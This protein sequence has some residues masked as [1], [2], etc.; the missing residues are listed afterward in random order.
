MSRNLFFAK[1]GYRISKELGNNREA[2]CITY[3][4]E[5]ND[6]EA[7]VVIKE[8]R[9]SG[10]NSQWWSSQ[11]C[12]EENWAKIT[13]DREI[14]ILQ[15]LSHPCIPRYLTSFKTPESYCV[16]QEYKKAPSLAEKYSFTLA[17]IKQIA[18]SVLE[19][20]VY[21]QQRIPAI[22]HRD[23]KPENI[24][25]D[26]QLNAYLID[27]GLARLS[28]KDLSVNS[29]VAGTL[30]F[31]AP[32]EYFGHSPTE[33][34]D[35]Y[36][37]GATLICL[38]SGTSSGDIGKLVNEEYRFDLKRLEPRLSSEFID[39]LSKMVEPNLKNRF[40]HAAIALEELKSISVIDSEVSTFKNLHKKLYK[41]LHQTI[42]TRKTMIFPGIASISALIVFGVTGANIFN[43]KLFSRSLRP[44]TPLGSSQIHWSMELNETATGKKSQRQ[45]PE[46]TK[47]LKTKNCWSCNLNNISLILANLENATLENSS[48]R[49][50]DLEEV[51]FQNANLKNTYFEGSNLER[52][53]LLS[54]NLNGSSL[55]KVE[56]QNA[57]LKG[58]D[59]QNVN[60]R[61]ANIFDANFK[62]VNLT[63]SDLRNV[64]SVGA[65]FQDANLSHVN[66]AGAKLQNA[67]L[68]NT[69]LEGVN[70]GNANLRGANLR[71]ANLKGA[72]LKGAILADVDFTGAN[73]EGI[74]PKDVIRQI[75]DR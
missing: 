28:N 4:A 12:E 2:G 31:M 70:L 15:Q 62:N 25:V 1:L 13:A 5:D 17:E 21:L 37:L 20:L 49:N 74:K 55:E 54:V 36:S 45:K 29:I 24:L 43:S 14:E 16:V 47:L 73:L 22:I 53:N 59:M 48:I 9:F 61:N 8:F 56:L 32:E 68:R 33:A 66:L 69:N 44:T 35:L 60:L 19:T 75:N 7:Q 72:N 46:F 11:K 67:D 34:S 51:N 38:L 26:Q 63:N 71:G 30:G 3:L 57:N 27:F 39:W 65:N 41:K 58:A 52:A 40:S 42:S 6:L 50:A 10:E 64:Y 23:I 18:T